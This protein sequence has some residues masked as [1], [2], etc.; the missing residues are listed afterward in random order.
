MLNLLLKAPLQPWVED[1]PE[2]EEEFPAELVHVFLFIIFPLMESPARDCV[3]AFLKS[4]SG[5]IHP[6]DPADLSGD[7]VS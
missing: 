3:K 2:E 6:L 1:F 5:C 7:V 4:T